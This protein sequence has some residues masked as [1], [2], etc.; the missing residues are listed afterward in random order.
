MA[1]AALAAAGCSK[2]DPNAI[3]TQS[4]H[5]RDQPT[6]PP[7]AL[8]NRTP[9]ASGSEQRG[10]TLQYVSLVN[11]DG[12]YDPHKT[13]AGPFFGQ[14]ALVYSRLLAFTDQGKGTIAPD[15]AAALPEQPDATTFV[16][17][18]RNGA[19][20]PDDGPLAGRAVTAEDV[21]ASIDRQYAGDGSFARKPA[22]S[23]VDSVSI[24]EAGVVSIKL[25]APYAPMLGVLAGVNAFIVPREYTDGSHSFSRSE[26]PGSGPFRWV[27]WSEGKLAS[28]A[29]NPSWFAGDGKQPFLDGVSLTQPRDTG[30]VE[31]GLRTK[32]YDAAFVGR[33]AADSLLKSIPQLQEQTFGQARFFGM[34]YYIPIPPYNDLRLRA[35]LVLALDRRAMLQRFFQ[36]SGEVNAW[37]SWPNTRWAM[38]QS[39]LSTIPG[40]RIDPAGREAD[41]KEARSLVAAYLSDKE[42]PGQLPLY[43]PEDTENSLGMGSLIRDQVKQATDLNIQVFPVTIDAIIAR[44][45]E[46]KAPWVCGPDDGWVDLDDWVFPYFHS[47]GPKNSF[48][49]RDAQ[50]DSAI[51]SQRA[52]LNENQRKEIGL[53]IQRR[54]I[55]LHAGVNLVSERVVSLAWPYVKD[56]PLDIKDGYQHRFAQTWLDPSDPSFRGR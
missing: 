55:Q 34:R 33:T 28:V 23:Q 13:G 24:P 5:S 32:K 18:L 29:R 45:L 11:G 38:P 26:Q 40:Y 46:G 14:Q 6:I 8:G 31:A 41:L 56:F 52:E 2:G 30:E 27:E 42:L 3:P 16:L 35:A 43:V 17:R 49:L 36:G 21:K 7:R 4:T 12:R 20:W 15:L 48:P 50:I 25:K 37:V 19:K 47:E 1:A 51:L 53:S 54:L 9:T 22:W 39:E 44:L 10:G